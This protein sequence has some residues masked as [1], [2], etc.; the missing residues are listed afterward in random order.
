MSGRGVEC[1]PQW[2]VID[3]ADRTCGSV[4]CGGCDQQT[5]LEIGIG[6]PVA[7]AFVEVAQALP[8]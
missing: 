6:I 3:A 5:L 4:M 7:E 2:Q 8:E 1:V